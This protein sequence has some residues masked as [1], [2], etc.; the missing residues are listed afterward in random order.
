MY[1]EKDSVSTAV[2]MTGTLNNL[3]TFARSVTCDEEEAK[4]RTFLD[5]N[6]FLHECEDTYIVYQC[7]LIDVVDSKGH[8]RLMVDED[9]AAVFRGENFLILVRWHGWEKDCSF[10][11]LKLS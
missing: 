1:P 8:L 7:H 11:F 4:V 5:Q 3:A 6:A 9:N 10:Y 2:K